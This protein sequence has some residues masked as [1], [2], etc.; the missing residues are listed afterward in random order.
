MR[1]TRDPFPVTFSSPTL[2]SL[3][4]SNSKRTNK[5][6]EPGTEYV[7]SF[8]LDLLTKRAGAFIPALH[9][10]CLAT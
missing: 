10:T 9:C 4:N 6:T 1:S 2:P 8:Y 3:Q 7:I 5:S